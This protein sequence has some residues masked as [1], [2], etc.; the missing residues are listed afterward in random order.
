MLSWL[1][2][3]GTMTPR[4]DVKEMRATRVVDNINQTLKMHKTACGD[5]KPPSC[6]MIYHEVA[7]RG[8]TAKHEVKRELYI[9]PQSTR[10]L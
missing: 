8:N 4:I 1:T 3:L 6:A 9:E 7:T 10:P 2:R 5:R